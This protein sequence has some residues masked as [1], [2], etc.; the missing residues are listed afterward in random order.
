MEDTEAGKFY[1]SEA[2]LGYRVRLCLKKRTSLEDFNS[3][4]LK[5]RVGMHSQLGKTVCF[6][7]PHP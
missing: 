3:L 7:L 1:M 2:G 5:L 6:A 4:R